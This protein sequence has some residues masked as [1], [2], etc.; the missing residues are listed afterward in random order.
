MKKLSSLIFG[1]VAGNLAIS[2]CADKKEFAGKVVEK[3]IVKE[4]YDIKQEYNFACE[5]G[6]IYTLKNIYKDIFKVGD[7]V[8]LKA[9]D[10]NQNKINGIFDYKI[11]NKTKI[12]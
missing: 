7:R 2:E 8:R 3:W 9:K 5:N 1:V 6:K 11:L 4:D 10:V 12:E